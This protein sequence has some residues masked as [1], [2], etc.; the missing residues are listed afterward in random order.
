[1]EPMKTKKIDPNAYNALADALAAI[2]WNK[3][4]WAR[5]LRGV[6]RDVPEVLSGLDFD[7]A[8]KRET[9]GQLVDRLM[10]DERRYQAT[11]ISLMMSVASMDTFPNLAGQEDREHLIAEAKR[12]VAELRK[13]TAPSG[14]C[15]RPRADNRSDGQGIRGSQQEPGVLAVD[16][17]AQGAVHGAAWAR[18]TAGA[19]PRL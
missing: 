14:D 15:R 10:G 16:S 6:L 13:W 1:M 5:Y 2:Y 11:S 19:R 4:P 3:K 7:G 9:A 18:L 8:T 12:T 17:E